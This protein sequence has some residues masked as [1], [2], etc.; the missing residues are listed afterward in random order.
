[1]NGLPKLPALPT[2]GDLGRGGRPL[3]IGYGRIFHEACAYS[4]LRTTED[5][6]RRMHHLTG[7]ALAKG[8]SLGGAELES[9]FPHA[10]L[11]GFVQAAK[12]AGDVEAVPL[13]SSLAVPNGPLT[14]AC[15][16]WVLGEL[17]AQVKAAG[18]LDGIYLALHGSMEVE[19]L[20]EAPEAVILRRIK[21]VVG[22]NVK[23]AA[24]FDLHGNLT[25]DIVEPLE[26]LVS[27]RTNPHWD[28][29]PTG[30][31]A[32]NRLIRSLRGHCRP[33]H[34]WR[35][36]PV[37]L[38]GGMTLDF[39]APMRAIYQLM[40]K[41][42]RDPRVLTTSF[43]VVHPF[44]SARDLG[45][46]V[47]VST[48]GDEALA[49]RLADQLADAVWDIRR[50]PLPKMF[51]IDEALDEV[52]RS[53]LRRL[54]P[55]TLV[56]AD[57][58]VGAGAPGGSTQI[59]KALVENGRGL[60]AF[61]P[62]HDPDA[63]AAA[64]DTPV[65]EAVSLTLVGTAG[66]EM[67]TVPLRAIVGAKLETPQG[68]RV[69]LDVGTLHVVVTTHPP[70]PIHPKFWR[71]LGL[72]LRRADVLVQK[73]FFHYRLFHL[74]SSFRHIPV[75]SEGATSLRRAATRDMPV[76][77]WPMSNPEGW[78]DGDRALRLGTP[79]RR[80][81][82][83]NQTGQTATAASPASL[84]CRVLP[85]P[86][87]DVRWRSPRWRS[88]NARAPMCRWRGSPM[89]WAS[90]VRRCCT[91]SRPR[92]ISSSTRWSSC[93]ASKRST[94]SRGSNGTSI[95]S[96][97]SSLSSARCTRFTTGARVA[98]SFSRRPSQRRR[99]SGSTRF[100]PPP[101]RSSRHIAEPP[102]SA[103]AKASPTGSSRRVI[104]MRSWPPAVR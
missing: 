34:A 98:S 18:P 88:S 21:A 20:A 23:I 40:K 36:L 15:F 85:T 13:S 31:R 61:V 46:S 79:L 11:T 5:D 99:A 60:R 29:A 8:A 77:S 58:I 12:L 43:F 49:E 35:K 81:G 48:D 64:W 50:V 9:F 7:E 89:R 2:S 102:W 53:P 1:V 39:V 59:V 55:I 52:V 74:L 44:T 32:G 14:L 41:L 96:I 56:D 91:T 54:G 69:R 78:R 38:G 6:F 92:P 68:R 76:P 83:S 86:K 67:P 57:D 42:E 63:V 51:S 25:R 30:F 17:V 4:P 93:S 37:V 94:C 10:E 97:G 90:N 80:G 84:S 62:V 95:R 22:D 47:H 66:Y 103:S 27:Y 45:W 101:V 26:V 71:E 16:E 33:V 28:L 87:S 100:S 73:N 104:Q 65:G 19:G 3:R 24:S 75:T 72:T 82:P 70:L